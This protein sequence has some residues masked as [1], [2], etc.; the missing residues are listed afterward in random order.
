MIENLVFVH[1][2]VLQLKYRLG[3]TNANRGYLKDDLMLATWIAHL[4]WS[5]GWV[6]KKKKIKTSS[7]Q[8]I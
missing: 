4:C 3:F 5:E 6:F 7:I 2:R 8:K 1:K